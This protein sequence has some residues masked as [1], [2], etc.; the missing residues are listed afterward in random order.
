MKNLAAI[1]LLSSLAAV[2]GC[3]T[4][5]AP[6]QRP[7]A[8]EP[9]MA[10][11]PIERPMAAAM[12]DA[13]FAP[14][15]YA[16]DASHSVFLWKIR[17]LG[18][19][20]TYGWFKDVTGSITVDP[21]PSKQSIELA[22][23][24]ESIDSHDGKRDDH[25]RSPDFFNVAQFPTIMFKSTKIGGAAG[26][27]LS[28]NGDLTIHGVTKPVTVQVTALGAGTD[29]LVHATHIGYETK[30]TIKRSDFDMKFMSQLI[31][32]DVELTIGIE[33]YRGGDAPKK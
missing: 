14:G 26:N 33:A 17:H 5:E 23:K 18:A 15:K 6:E 2:A 13:A 11:K 21:D 12:G 31:G 22:I 29:P 7:T 1:A 30:L 16:V 4:A 9:V 8:T 20:Y 24:A 19:G 27:Q 28:V 25:M 32:D 10:G 3:K